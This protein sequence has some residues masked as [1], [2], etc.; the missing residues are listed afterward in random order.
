MRRVT[1]GALWLALLCILTGKAKTPII[2]RPGSLASMDPPVPAPA[3]RF[4][5]QA[6]SSLFGRGALQMLGDGLGP[7]DEKDRPGAADRIKLEVQ[8]QAPPPLKPGLAKAAGGS[9]PAHGR[10]AG[11]EQIVYSPPSALAQLPPKIQSELES[12]GCRIPRPYGG[13]APQNV[14]R[15]ELRRRGQTDWAVLCS[16][17]NIS[18]ILVFWKGSNTAPA[19]IDPL[20][21]NNFLTPL[22]DGKI[23][24]SRAISPVGK[25]FIMTH[26]SAYGGPT[27]PPIEHEGINDEFLEKGSVVHYFYRGRWLRL[28]GSD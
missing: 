13:V 20:P 8:L 3:V 10:Q 12:R 1:L 25:E 11:A 19:E 17:K 5:P 4:T 21:D 27:P 18:S 7:S 14:I 15:G 22:A 6:P 28:T 23:G 9:G 2:E 26:F 16:K 24:Y